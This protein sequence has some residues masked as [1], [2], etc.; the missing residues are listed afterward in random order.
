[1]RRGD[2]SQPDAKRQAPS[3]RGW[4]RILSNTW[5]EIGR[6][7]VVVMAAG[8]AFFSFLSVFPA[9]STAISAF[10]LVADPRTIERQLVALHGLLPPAAMELLTTQLRTLIAAP[11]AGLGIGLA[12]SLLF[13]FW[14]ATSGVSTLMSA[15]TAAY[16]ERESR[17]LLTFYAQAFAL[18]I[19]VGAFA[20]I[21]LF[22]IAVVPA[23][24]AWLPFPQTWRKLIALIRWPILAALVYVAL[25]LVYR[26]AP[27]REIA[28]W[29][30]LAPGTI[31]AA[32]LWLGGSAGFSY[33]VANFGTY[34]EMYGSLGTVV[35]LL[36]WFYIS[37][38][39]VLAGAELNA[40]ADKARG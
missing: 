10:G 2:P 8:V 26:F 11:Q 14:S 1:V 19:G 17:S 16:N 3:R 34:N 35:A 5:T 30:W 20:L 31:A 12:V 29:H 9:M 6:D 33:Y 27:S 37:A 23:V 15:L 39:I 28:R 40:E 25:A 36:M 32:L 24:I 7:F 13:T 38:F 22:L 4:K 21:S 18:T